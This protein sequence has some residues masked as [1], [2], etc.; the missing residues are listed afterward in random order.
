MNQEPVVYVNG[1][2]LCRSEAKVSVYDQGLMFG[3]GVFEGIRVY[4][5]R[6]F[7]C[8]EH[9]A[10]LCDGA[11]YLAIEMPLT[12]PEIKDVM[13]ETCRRN[14]AKDGYIRF[15]VT[16]GIGDLSLFP[17]D[18]PKPTVLCIVAKLSLYP[19]EVYEKGM[20]IITSVQRRNRASIL[21]PQIKSLNYLN[22]ILAKIEALRAGVPEA[23]MLTDSGIVAECSGDNI[24][25]VKDGVVATPPLHVGILNGITRRS[26]IR[27][28][29]EIGIGV[30]EREFTLFN[31][32]AAD[33]CFLTGTGAEI[34]SVCSVDG[35]TIG[36]GVPGPA[37]KKL[38]KAFHEYAKTQGTPIYEERAAAPSPEGA[39]P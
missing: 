38:K 32:Y 10:R 6:I 4:G 39:R 28:A 29:R 13:I 31:V 14:N 35:R 1:E 27:L 11:K 21:D 7:K 22:N 26:V 18:S 19:R 30:E 12:K 5:G 24:F 3:D 37:S 25:I 15:V 17:P 9:I 8:D 23:L 2:F 16:R 33:E 34:V 36:D 20:S